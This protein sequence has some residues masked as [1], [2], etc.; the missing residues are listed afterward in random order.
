MSHPQQSWP[1]SDS[2]VIQQHHMITT[3]APYLGEGGALSLGLQ[4]N[5]MSSAL[6]DLVNILL[7]KPAQP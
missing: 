3:H 7:T 1:A 5:H 4:L 6:Q 2:Q